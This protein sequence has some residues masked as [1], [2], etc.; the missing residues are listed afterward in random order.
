[1]QPTRRI[2]RQKTEDMPNKL[3]S[4]RIGR[5]MKLSDLAKEIGVTVQ[6]LRQAEVKGDGIGKDKWYK[7]ADFFDIDPRILESP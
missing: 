1:M 5:Q 4:L 7:L 6:A 2:Y 3:R